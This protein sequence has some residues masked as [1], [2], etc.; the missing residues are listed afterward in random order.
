MDE[1]VVLSIKMPR[2]FLFG[3]MFLKL[4]RVSPNLPSRSVSSLSQEN[5]H[6][7]QSIRFVG[8]EP[9]DSPYYR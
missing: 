1:A 8:I 3:L 5:L 2:C 6:L 4:H 9:Y 7:A